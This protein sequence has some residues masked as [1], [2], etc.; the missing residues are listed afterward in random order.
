MIKLYGFGAN[1]GLFDA[2]PF[3]VKVDAF[4]RMAGI[5]HTFNGNV[6]NLQ[7]APKGK[8]PYIDDDGTIVADSELIID[9]LVNKYGDKLDSE[10]T[11]QQKAIAYLIRKSLD[12][13]FY[14]TIVYS[15]WIDEQS[16]PD[17][18]EGFF[19]K[20]PFPL[21]VIVPIVARRGVQKA[22]HGHGIGRHDKAEIQ[23]ICEKTLDSLSK[24]LGDQ[25]W[26]LSD[27][28]SS[29]DASVY[30]FV[31]SLVLMDYDNPFNQMAKKYDN[32]VAFCE[33]I[34][35]KYYG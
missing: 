7:K 3:V 11:E 16:W 5:E 8:L 30:A 27:K 15:R 20:M 35:M 25:E 23:Q 24:M 6:A 13:N 18:R 21:K 26:F 14:W 9:H 19:G 28:P 12:E 4:M 34:Q 1:F 22:I 10:L 2:S 17:I 32:L 31:G 33:R 29:L